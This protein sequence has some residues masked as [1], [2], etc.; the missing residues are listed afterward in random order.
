MTGRVAGVANWLAASRL[1][2]TREG[3]RVASA[4][5]VLSPRRPSDCVVAAI[6]IA[7]ALRDC[8]ERGCDLISHPTTFSPTTL[9]PPHQPLHRIQRTHL[10]RPSV[11]TRRRQQR[12]RRSTQHQPPRIHRLPIH[13]PPPRHPPPPSAEFAWSRRRPTASSPPARARALLRT[14]TSS[15]CKRGS[16]NG[17]ACSCAKSAARPTRPT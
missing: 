11:R 9:F 7:R 10:A 15:A 8:D 2:S 1:H 6:G 5:A 3:A 4:T 16:K 12:R 17:A 13:P 14:R